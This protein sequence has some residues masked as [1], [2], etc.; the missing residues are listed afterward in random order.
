MPEGAGEAG[1]KQP[2]STTPDSFQFTSDKLPMTV[3]IEEFMYS[4]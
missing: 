2:A 3:T 1:F 4:E